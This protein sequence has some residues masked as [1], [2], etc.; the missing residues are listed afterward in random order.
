VQESSFA[1]GY[2]KL[3]TISQ[4]NEFARPLDANSPFNAEKNPIPLHL[5]SQRQSQAQITRPI[6]HKLD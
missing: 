4:T 5:S 3:Q 2:F 6:V 1:D